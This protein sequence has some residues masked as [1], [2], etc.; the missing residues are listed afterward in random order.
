[1]KL[2]RDWPM[3]SQMRNTTSPSEATNGR[4]E[5]ANRFVRMKGHKYDL[6][7]RRRQHDIEERMSKMDDLIREYRVRT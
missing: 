6:E 7:K 4:I 5:F 1:M 3:D 2:F